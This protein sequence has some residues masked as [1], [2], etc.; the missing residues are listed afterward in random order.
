[1]PP[2]P[3]KAPKKIHHINNVLVLHTN[4][5][6]KHNIRRVVISFDV[7]HYTTAV[8]W[9]HN[10]ASSENRRKIQTKNILSEIS[11]LKKDR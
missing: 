1:M 9:S 10:N 11:V 5:K 4:V 6:T 8:E 3:V 2:N 7:L